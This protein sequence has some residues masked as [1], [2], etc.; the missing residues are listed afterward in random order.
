MTAAEIRELL[1]LHALDLLEG[2]EAVAVDRAVASDANLA[3]EL[4][5]LRDAAYSIVDAPVAPPPDIERRLMASVG[6]GRFEKFAAR[7]GQLLDLAIDPVRELLGRIERPW[8]P[9]EAPGVLLI[10]FTAGPACAT[11]DCGIVRVEPGSMFP[12]HTHLGEEHSLIVSGRLRDNDG[13]EYGPGDEYV[14]Q[15]GT[16][17]DLTAIGDEPVIFVARAFNGIQV[18]RRPQA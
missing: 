5:S 7:L 15:T 6:G 2:D 14:A 13:R 8:P 3:G 9:E 12:W 11:A 18:G 1:P 4:A 10:H 17:H 16:S